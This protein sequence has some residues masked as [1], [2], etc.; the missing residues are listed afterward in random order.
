MSRAC[1]SMTKRERE[2]FFRGYKVGSSSAR[3]MT[4]DYFRKMREGG[5]PDDTA[6][7]L[8]LEVRNRFGPGSPTVLEGLPM[9]EQRDTPTNRAEAKEMAA[10]AFHLAQKASEEM[11]AIDQAALPAGVWDVLYDQGEAIGVLATAVFFLTHGV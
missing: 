6:I 9:S 1:E 4:E 8:W 3:M 11:N 7:D 5:I 10:N 2:A